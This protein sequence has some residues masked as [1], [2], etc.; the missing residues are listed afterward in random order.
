VFCNHCRTI[1]EGVT[2]NVVA[3][4]GC[5]AALFVRDHFSKRLNA[6]AGVQVDAEAP[7]EIPAIEEL[8]A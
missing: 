5:N 3:C 2:T 7:G 4:A 1:T 6:F 8:Y